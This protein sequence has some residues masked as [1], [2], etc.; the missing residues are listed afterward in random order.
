[1]QIIKK[2]NNNIRNI[3]TKVIIILSVFILLTVAISTKVNFWQFN[4]FVRL[5]LFLLVF[6]IITGI[7]SQK[8][9]KPFVLAMIIVMFL[10]F[11]TKYIIKDGGSK[12][13]WAPLYEVIAWNQLDDKDDQENIV[14]G[15]HDTEIFLFP[16]N[17]TWFGDQDK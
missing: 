14:P 9:I 2:R 1:M 15:R 5:I 7:D 12:M 10:L 6:Y 8:S 3:V 16:F 4:S 17:T 13:Y 11:P